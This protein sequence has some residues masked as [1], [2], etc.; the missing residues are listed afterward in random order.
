MRKC[1]IQQTLQFNNT[2]SHDEYN[3]GQL[4]P[5]STTQTGGC[6]LSVSPDLSNT[7]IKLA[8]PRISLDG[9]F[10][11]GFEQLLP[12]VKEKVLGHTEASSLRNLYMM[13]YP[14]QV[15]EHF[16]HFYFSSK[17]AIYCDNLFGS[18]G[19]NSERSSVIAAYWPTVAGSYIAHGQT[20]MIA[21]GEIQ[22]FVKHHTTFNRRGET[23]K[24]CH[25]FAYVEWFVNHPSWDSYGSNCIICYPNF[26]SHNLFSFIPISRIYCKCAYGIHDIKLD[27]SNVQV[28]IASPIS[29]H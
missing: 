15:I 14:N 12:P 18:K 29:F 17:R 27:G 9:S 10:V 11:T 16:S 22:Y 7:I 20:F 5:E 28:F 25:Y 1:L 19:S 13:L 2:N 26:H 6:L 4:L 8:L 3:F 23:V 24:E 21:A